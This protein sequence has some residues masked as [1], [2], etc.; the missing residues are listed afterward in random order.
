M[1]TATIQAYDARAAEFADRYAAADLAP[2]HRLLLAHLPPRCR[3]LEIGCGTGRDA[4][5]LA[6]NGFR[7]VAAD[8]SAAMLKHLHD[9]SD[10]T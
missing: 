5:F 8:A 2:L 9:F 4:A 7:L 6:S 3:V 10:I 1:D